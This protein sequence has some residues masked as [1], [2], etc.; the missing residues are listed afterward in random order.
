MFDPA[1][2]KTEKLGEFFGFGVA[3]TIFASLLFYLLNRFFSLN[4][5]ISYKYAISG[6][7]FA[8]VLRRAI[9]GIPKKNEK[10]ELI[11]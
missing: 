10:R 4:Q 9:K 1:R 3:M 5:Y 8:Y 7:L 11:C 6:V 2:S